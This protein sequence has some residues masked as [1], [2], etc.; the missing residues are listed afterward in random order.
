MFIKIII[1]LPM[2][3]LPRTKKSCQILKI[4]RSTFKNF[5]IPIPKFGF[6][7]WKQELI[8]MVHLFESFLSW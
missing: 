1:Y 5:G 6:V 4:S 7:F 3:V 8:K 2:L